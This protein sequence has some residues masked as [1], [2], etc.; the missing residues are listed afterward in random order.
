MND[1]DIIIQQLE[2]KND[3]L[4][5][6]CKLLLELNKNYFYTINELNETIKNKTENI[7]SLYRLLL[8]DKEYD[9]DEYWS[10]Y[11]QPNVNS[12]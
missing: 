10:K 1:K 6:K 7:N 9:N 3:M 2:E 12:P 4:I 11:F 5:K 8:L